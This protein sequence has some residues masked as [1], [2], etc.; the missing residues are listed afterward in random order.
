M[1]FDFDCSVV[2]EEK[3][4]EECGWRQQTTDACLHYKLTYDL[5]AQV[6]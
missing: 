1:K 2:S 4:F 3:I 6:G 5:S